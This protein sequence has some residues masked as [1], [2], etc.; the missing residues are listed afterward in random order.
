MPCAA[1]GSIPFLPQDT[2]SCLKNLYLRFGLRAW[3]RYGFVNAFNPLTGWT[4]PDAIGICTGISMVM[5]ENHRSGLVWRSFMG[6]PE[7]QKA[8]RL[9]GFQPSAQTVETA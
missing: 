9:V 7:A 5:A 2:L 4:D 1:A 3:K 8:M 6:N